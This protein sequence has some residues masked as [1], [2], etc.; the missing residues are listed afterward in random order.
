MHC[1]PSRP[2]CAPTARP[3]PRRTGLLV[4]ALVCLGGGLAG[5]LGVDELLRCW[6]RAGPVSAGTP[7]WMGPQTHSLVGSPA[8][9]FRL[10][11][12]ADGRQV[13]QPDLGSRK[14]VV[15]IFS[16]FN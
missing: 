15:L 9:A 10:P 12:G 8:P 7:L 6:S 4:F 5:A 16:G 2:D 13:R 1:Q 14:P 11:A 3:K